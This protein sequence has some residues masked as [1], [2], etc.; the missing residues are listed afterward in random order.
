MAKKYGNT[1]WGQQWLNALENIDYS[2]RLPRGRSYANKGAVREIDIDKNTVYAKVKGSQPKPYQQEISVNLFSKE[3][4]EKVIE[5]ITENP[6]ILSALLNKELPQELLEELNQEGIQL[7]PK[8]WEDMRAECSCPD[9]AVPCKHIASVIYVIANEIDKNPFLVF[10]LHDLDILEEIQKLGFSSKGAFK[11]P[12]QS[13]ENIYREKTTSSKQELDLEKLKEIDFSTLPESRENILKLLAKNPIFFSEADFQKIV[14]KQY[15]VL[16]RECRKLQEVALDFDK[17]F[18]E[19]NQGEIQIFIDSNLQ[20]RYTKVNNSDKQQSLDNSQDIRT[21]IDLIEQINPAHLQNHHPSTVALY[22]TYRFALYLAIQSAFIPELVEVGQ[23]SYAIRWIPALLI[24]SVKKIFEILATFISPKILCI[25]TR[26]TSLY[27]QNQE[28]ALKMLL[29]LFLTHFQNRYF[30][31]ERGMITQ[32]EV[33]RLFFKQSIFES[34][35][36]GREETP[37]AIQKWLQKFYLAEKEFVPIL[38]VEEREYEGEFALSFWIQNQKDTLA[39]LISVEDLFKKKK[40]SKIRLEI[41]QDLSLLAEYLPQVKELIKSK[42]EHQIFVDSEDFV[43][44][45]M[46]TLPALQLLNIQVLL[47]KALRRLARP[48]LS[49]RIQTQGSSGASENFVNLRNMLAFEWQVALGEDLLSPDDFRKL[50]RKLKGIVKINDQ[51]VLIDEKEIQTI[52]K[53]LDNPPSL[54]ASDIFRSA[55]SQDYKGAKVKL[56]QKARELLRKMVEFEVIAPPQNLQATLR[57]YQKTGY[58]WLYKNA[59]LGF[60]SLLADDMGLGKTL[61]VIALLLKMKEEGR[62]DKQ[63]ALV[64]VP[65]TLLGNWDREIQKFASD[66]RALIYHGQKR[67]LDLENYDVIL[68]SYGVARSDS[69]DLAKIKWAFLAIDEAQN[70]KNTSTAQSKAIKKLKSASIVAMSGTPVENRLSEY[71]SI[72]DF[73]NKSYLGTL[74]KFKDE[75][76]KPIELERNQEQVERFRKITAPFILRRVKTDKSIIDDLPDKIET[77]QIC[78]LSKEQTALYQNVV[79]MIMKEINSSEG[80]QRKGLIFQLMNAL[81]QICNHPNHYL[82]KTQIDIEQSGKTQMLVSLLDNIYENGE[83]TLIFTQYKE[84]GDLLS[85]LIQEKYHAV[86]L[87]LHGGISRKKRDEM[88]EDFQNKPYVKTMLLSLKAGGTGLNLTQAS[89]VIHYDLWWNPA[90]ENQATDRA[91][92]IGQQNNVMVYRFITQGT[93]EEKINEMIQ[94]KK[95]LADLTVSTGENWIG[96]MSNE[97]LRSVFSL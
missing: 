6:F 47:P 90:V 38:K 83:K 88:V 19:E 7:F 62:L 48:Q 10:L 81:K 75:F 32:N 97:D 43:S 35:G 78:T 39:K 60:G 89:N 80:I 23:N 53:K 11:I 51:Y 76:I 55:L 21:L 9:W 65:T 85:K 68:T 67:V 73:T 49:G 69:K 63:K 37:Q 54:N 52:L 28:E 4:K 95:E 34:K 26:K 56:D 71:W 86:P 8:N 61:Q 79:D 77:D 12:I 72:F 1:W 15:K 36:F 20:Y 2:N 16:A 45:F 40:Y 25:F 94:S 18:F 82:K 22:L 27:A 41:L 74:P 17:N 5:I 29:S 42:G 92:R 87:W 13:L 14:D 31:D 44:I 70:I 50:V 58:E 57:P 46:D 64:I 66:L 33:V 30:K 3:E 93:F 24:D 59:Q 84:M 91:Y 96:D